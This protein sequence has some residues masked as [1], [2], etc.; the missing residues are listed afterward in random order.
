[1]LGAFLSLLID[2]YVVEE[3]RS[4]K[5]KLTERSIE[6]QMESVWHGNPVLQFIE[7][8][9]KN[10][11]KSLDTL[12]K[13]NMPVDTFIGSFQPWAQSQ[14]MP[15]RTDGDILML[16]KNNFVVGWKGVKVAGKVENKKRLRAVKPETQAFIDHLRKEM[17]SAAE[18][19]SEELVGD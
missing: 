17:T 15:E 18:D 16:V 19:T 14:K 9:A 3:E 2:H 5:L 8:L 12:E 13:G 7:H 1:M 11:I 4:E 6:L 10:D